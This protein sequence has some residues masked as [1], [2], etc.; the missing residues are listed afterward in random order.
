M[1][2]EYKRGSNTFISLLI[3]MYP[4][5]LIP[6][7]YIRKHTRIVYGTYL[8]FLFVVSLS[9][10]VTYNQF[11][12]RNRLLKYA[13]Y[14]HTFA[15]TISIFYMLPVGIN[16]L[17]KL[18]FDGNLKC[19][20]NFNFLKTSKFSANFIAILQENIYVVIEFIYGIVKEKR[21]SI[22]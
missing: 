11:C 1:K 5:I 7:I 17:E 13:H 20:Y 12:L 3:I 22:K 19:F 9:P 18:T 2:T 6:G 21:K 10:N 15:A 4:Y 8:T 16:R 14:F